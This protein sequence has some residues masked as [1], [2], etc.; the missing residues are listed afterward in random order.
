MALM[1]LYR[2]KDKFPWLKLPERKK[3]YAER[4]GLKVIKIEEISDI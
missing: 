1:V 3:S 4:K 2:N